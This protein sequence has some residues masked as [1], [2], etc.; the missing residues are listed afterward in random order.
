MKQECVIHIAYAEPHG[1]LRSI[2]SE[3]ISQLD[4]RFNVFIK[5]NDGEDLLAKI[6]NAK[7]QPD[8]CIVDICMPGMNGYNTVKQI[9]KQF[10]FIKCL[11]LSNSDIEF[12]VSKFMQSG[13]HG[14]LT[15]NADPSEIRQA[16]IE[17]YNNNHYFSSDILKSM[18]GV[19]KMDGEEFSHVILSEREIEFLTFCSSD[20]TY[21]EIARKMHLS[22]RSV[23]NYSI[24]I[25]NK[26]KIESRMG[27]VMFAINTGINPSFLHRNNQ[28]DTK[29]LLNRSTLRNS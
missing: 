11:A 26:L 12:C 27:L 4:S 2:I 9:K 8:V 16:I 5:A 19:S 21:T 3:Y 14:Y 23:E 25:R 1:M 24:R 20:M 6:I 28:P 10:P 7:Y 22:P 17:V 13:A 18:P 29:N 15:K